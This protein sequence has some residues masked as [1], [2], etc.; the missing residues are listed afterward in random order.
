LQEDLDGDD[1]GDVCDNCA[2][3][4]PLQLDAD[5]DGVGDSYLYEDETGA[6][7]LSVCDNCKDVPMLTRQIRTMT[8]MATCATTARILITKTSWKM[9]MTVLA[10]FVRA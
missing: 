5:A 4:N 1:A 3:F 7:I 2:A 10:T 8:V 9:T 6:S